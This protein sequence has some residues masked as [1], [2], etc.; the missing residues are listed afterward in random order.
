MS[1]FDRSGSPAVAVTQTFL[2]KLDADG[3]QSK[4]ARAKLQGYIKD[5]IRERSVREKLIPSQPIQPQDC[6]PS[7]YTEQ[8][9]RIEF[10]EPKSRA[11]P[12]TFRSEAEATYAYA[13]RVAFGFYKI[14]TPRVEMSEEDLMIYAV[15]GVPIYELIEK[16]AVTDQEEVKDWFWV[17]WSEAACRANQAALNV[18]S[19]TIG[20][21][22][23]AL[24]AGTVSEVSIYKG[25][26]ARGL[27]GGGGA[28]VSYTPYAPQ[29]EDFTMLGQ[30]FVGDDDPR[31]QLWKVLIAEYD[32]LSLSNWASDE[33]DT[34]SG[35][36]AVEGWTYDKVVGY[37]YVRCLK[38]SVLP[39]GSMYGYTKPE[40]MGVMYQLIG[41][42]FYLDKIVDI[43]RWQSWVVEGGTIANVASIRKIELFAGSCAPGLEDNVANAALR[44]PVAEEDLGGKQNHRAEFGDYM[45]K[46]DIFA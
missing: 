39:R 17:I 35:K 11:M 28:D 7:L 27:G 44:L 19:A 26:I 18:A 13:A 6:T 25:T 32:Y 8:L 40:F 20:L 37:S 34:Q 4:V 16:N 22:T 9:V 41:P 33:V 45:P 42:K 43:I 15:G 14:G 2:D 36:V 31:L 30:A 24:T 10:L 3:G 5:Q 23:A 29:R 46:A 38:G 21:S 1:T 12:L